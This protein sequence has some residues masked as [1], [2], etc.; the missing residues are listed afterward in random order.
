[1]QQ[2]FWCIEFL[3]EKKETPSHV[4]KNVICLKLYFGNQ[5]SC[6]LFCVI[7]FISPPR[8]QCFIRSQKI[9]HI[10]IKPLH[11]RA[12]H[13]RSNK[14]PLFFLKLNSRT[15][16][17][18]IFLICSIIGNVNLM[19]TKVYA[20]H[21]Q[22]FVCMYA[23]NAYLTIYNPFVVVVV[24]VQFVVLRNRKQKTKKKTIYRCCCCFT[25]SKK[26][27]QSFP[28]YLCFST[29]FHSIYPSVPYIH[30]FGK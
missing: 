15:K 27:V 8:P 22:F 24:V 14:S 9:S 13:K 28:S 23:W 19:G 21:S 12:K 16:V 25:N 30:V 4:L 20:L 7:V 18:V 1:M 29:S 6:N 11:I 10:Y 26:K 2:T 17:E 3:L 5:I